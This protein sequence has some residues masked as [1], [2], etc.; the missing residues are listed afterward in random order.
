MASMRAVKMSNGRF[1]KPVKGTFYVDTLYRQGWHFVN[2]Q[3]ED[4]PPPDWYTPPK[5][6]VVVETK[7]MALVTGQAPKKRGGR[8]KGSKNKR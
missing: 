7:G 1:T 2:D 4:I 8:P 6:M 3:G 5:P